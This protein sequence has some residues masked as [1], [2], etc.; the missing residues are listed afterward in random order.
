MPQSYQQEKAENSMM[1]TK[2]IHT[3]MASLVN[4][5]KIYRRNNTQFNTNCSLKQERWEYLSTCLMRP[6]LFCYQNETNMLQDEKTI[7][8]QPS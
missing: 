3:V 6:A 7:D 8:Q 4:S 2:E 1:D 5:T